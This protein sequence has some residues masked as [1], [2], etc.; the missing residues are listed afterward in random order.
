MTKKI[1]SFAAIA[2]SAMAS[3]A[4]STYST[5]GQ[6][7]G[8]AAY[9]PNGG[10]ANLTFQSFNLSAAVTSGSTTSFLYLTTGHDNIAAANAAVKLE[11]IS[12]VWGAG[13]HSSATIGSEDPETDDAYLV[14]TTPN[15]VVVAI[16]AAGDAKWTA[17]GTTSF[18]F[19]DTVIASAARYRFY[20]ATSVAGISVGN[21]LTSSQYVV[22][23]CNSKYHN[24]STSST[25]DAN[26]G[27]S[28]GDNLSINCSITVGEIETGTVTVVDTTAEGVSVDASTATLPIVVNGAVA[29]G[30]VDL[31]GSALAVPVVVT[32]NATTLKLSEALTVSPYIYFATT[33]SST[34]D[35]SALPETG[36]T[37]GE[38]EDTK[39]TTVVSGNIGYLATPSATPP[40]SNAYSTL[41]SVSTTGVSVTFAPAG[42]DASI[43]M[44]GTKYW[45]Q[46]KP[47]DWTGYANGRVANITLTQSEGNQ[48]SGTLVFDEDVTFGVL[49]VG[50]YY[51]TTT[52]FAVE[53]ETGRTVSFDSISMTI[54]PT[55]VT[56]KNFT[57]LPV[58]SP[59]K[60]AANDKITLSGT[61]TLASVPYATDSTY[62]GTWV[63]GQ[64]VTAGG[65]FAPIG[66]KNFRFN[67][68]TQTF[69]RMVLGNEYGVT[70]VVDVDSGT[71]NVT[72]DGSVESGS[73]TTAPLL[74]GH[75]NS[76]AT[77]N[78][79]GGSVNVTGATRV[80]WDG[81]GT[82]N[83][84]GA[85]TTAT[86]T[87]KGIRNGADG[88]GGTATVNVMTNG[89]LN[90]TDSRG[91]DFNSTAGTFNLMGGTVNF[92]ADSKILTSAGYFV[93]A[94][95][96]TS[97]INVAAGKTLSIKTL[98][99]GNGNLVFGGDGTVDFEWLR[100]GANVSFASGVNVK[101]NAA[102]QDDGAISLNAPAGIA[103]TIV[104]SDGATTQSVSTDENGKVSY[105]VQTGGQAAWLEYEF[106]YE[107]GGSATGFESTGYSSSAL[108]SDSGITGLD[109]FTGDG[110]LYTYA[111]P[112]KNITY[113]DSWSAAVRCTVPKYPL[114]AIVTFGTNSGGLIGLVAGQTEGEMLLVRTTSEL[115]TI[116]EGNGT[117]LASMK[118]ANATVSQHVYVFTKSDRTIKVYCDG[119]LIS[120]YTSDEDITFGS[121]LQVGSVHGGVSGMNIIRFAKGEAAAN[122][123]SEEDQKAA[124][125][126]FLRM[127]EGVIG[128]RAIAKLTE[129]NPYVSASGLS[130]RT[131]SAASEDWSQAGAWLITPAS[132][133]AYTAADPLAGSQIAITASG[134]HVVQMNGAENVEYESIAV[135]GEGSV[136]FAS[137]IAADG[138]TVTTKSISPISFKANVDTSIQ[139]GTVDLV[140]VSVTVAADCTLTFDFSGYETLPV[141]RTTYTAD[142]TGLVSGDGEVGFVAA[143]A[144]YPSSLKYIATR[145]VY[146]FVF[147]SDHYGQ[148]VYWKHGETDLDADTKVVVRDGEN[149]TEV[150]LFTEDVIVFDAEDAIAI[151]E[152]GDLKAYFGALKVVNGG[153]LTLSGGGLANRTVILDGG[154]FD[155]DST[156]EL[157]GTI[158]F[159]VDSGNY[160]IFGDGAPDLSSATILKTGAGTL[161]IGGDAGTVDKVCVAEGVL[162]FAD[163]AT[164]VDSIL[165]ASGAVARF[166]GN[167][168]LQGW[169]GSYKDTTGTLDIPANAVFTSTLQVTIPVTGAGRLLAADGDYSKVL[170]GTSIA[171]LQN[172]S[173]WTGTLH[174]DG[175][176]L[177]ADV[178]LGSYG[179]SASTIEMS[180]CSGFLGR[181]SNLG[182]LS[183][184][185]D[186]ALTIN[187]GYSNNTNVFAALTG[188]GTFSIVK[189]SGN[190]TERIIVKDASSFYGSFL[191]DSAEAGSQ[192]GVYIGNVSAITSDY[193][194]GR[195]TIDSTATINIAAGKEWFASGG[196]EVY[197]KVNISGGS[198]SG[199]V[200]FCDGSSIDY[201]GEIP[202]GARVKLAG[203]TPATTK[204]YVDGT[205]TSISE[206]GLATFMAT[207]P[208]TL[209]G[210]AFPSN[211]TLTLG[212]DGIYAKS[213][214]GGFSLHVR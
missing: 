154:S 199:D 22:A 24:S 55:Y 130:T 39:T 12:V 172:A 18:A 67:T 135:G 127:Y 211:Y 97:Y 80:G 119:D 152:S 179:N 19:T 13:A 59:Y 214:S 94:D 140:G 128:P 33:G 30:V 86:L 81:A 171:A 120:T 183:L 117:I 2:M 129:E 156:V 36:L 76:T 106:E 51:A 26:V 99:T 46:V 56:F 47:A 42:S 35:L 78:I 112:W 38:D 101:F 61:E 134:D 132:G 163:D 58:F 27:S 126:D 210:Q 197:G 155:V 143:N 15:N 96:K 116:A 72:S 28:Y 70:Q 25:A 107:D 209:N 54:D 73:N 64:P 115:K 184:T 164:V 66:T 9:T 71:I 170:N 165:V 207:V 50:T 95:G 49:T 203:F 137:T 139:P 34:I 44:G 205:A 14:L 37:P 4:S 65:N 151:T 8:L 41:T 194:N 111:H 212:S 167:T 87:T 11:S 202:Q 138:F 98:P 193:M 113:P 180:G 168:A 144:P 79:N 69:N 206:A 6:V 102:T 175:M 105:T 109:A 177:T 83:I 85:N 89:V 45:S 160:T 91:I 1:L 131:L 161:T 158:T 10:N 7:A 191:L 181:N 52:D 178:P 82:V 104:N 124:R 153:A 121:G 125:I 162:E 93:L 92:N 176:V 201:V 62:G 57:S 77:L 23:R 68:A 100:P 182:T 195:I 150:S 90:I 188:T 20:F 173:G 200:T 145:Q 148:T 174:L 122:T 187:N 204:C 208:I 84:G 186:S 157:G 189:P 31:S 123:L 29:N 196:I 149:E 63:V 190:P 136:A 141:A 88:H 166:S 147:G 114:A 185:G 21:V 43:E 146:Q 32:G 213:S 133:D 5:F 16:S 110:M 192:Y 3:F 40:A 198:F 53:R 17:N 60:T 142:I 75:W 48:T 108:N 118:V 103:V 74:V 159:Q 169:V